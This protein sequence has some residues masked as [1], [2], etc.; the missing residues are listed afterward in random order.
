[1]KREAKGK[2]R[3]ADSPRSRLPQAEAPTEPSAPAEAGAGGWEGAREEAV[4]PVEEAAAAASGAALEL[5]RGP[6]EVAPPAGPGGSPASPY[7]AE[8]PETAAIEPPRDPAADHARE[9]LEALRRRMFELLPEWAGRPEDPASVLLELCAE[10]Y[11]ELQGEIER[12]EDAAVPRLIDRLGFQPL[13]PRPARGVVI[14]R[15]E[16]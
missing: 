16:P 12:L 2:K 6:E 3:R 11:G 9:A 7:E 14:L 13:P 1:M 4:L 5:L 15:P 10:L 8:R